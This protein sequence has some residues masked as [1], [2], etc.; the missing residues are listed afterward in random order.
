MTA[1]LILTRTHCIRNYPESNACFSSF[2]IDQSSFQSASSAMSNLAKTLGPSSPSSSPFRRPADD[3]AIFFPPLSA[4]HLQ[5]S[6]YIPSSSGRSMIFTTSRPSMGKN[7]KPWPEP[8][9]QTTTPARPGTRSTT[10]ELSTLS[11]YQHSFVAETSRPSSSGRWLRM[12]PEKVSEEGA[13]SLEGGALG[14]RRLAFHRFKSFFGDVG[15]LFLGD[16]SCDGDRDSA[17]AHVGEVGPPAKM[18][19]RQLRRILQSV[20]KLRAI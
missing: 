9:E 2:C 1:S 14:A 7:L 10:K 12:K 17:T 4:L 19:G 16:V 15:L 20:Y 8:P 5:R 3:L 11:V 13:R 6:R 18:D